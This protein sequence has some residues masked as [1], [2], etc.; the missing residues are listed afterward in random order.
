MEEKELA[1]VLIALSRKFAR[2]ENPADFAGGPPQAGRS[3]AVLVPP[4][5]PPSAEQWM[6]YQCGSCLTVYEERYGAP[7]EGIDPGTAFADLSPEW[8]CSLCGAGREAFA[9]VETV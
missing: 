8:G 4:A 7:E 2:G 1:D 9:L 3:T 6:G 5:A